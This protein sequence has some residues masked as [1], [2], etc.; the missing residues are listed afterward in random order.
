MLNKILIILLLLIGECCVFRFISSCSLVALSCGSK[1][2]RRGAFFPA[3]LWNETRSEKKVLLI[4]A[5]AKR[6]KARSERRNIA[7]AWRFEPY[8]EFTRGINKKRNEE[9]YWL[10]P[11]HGFATFPTQ[12]RHIPV[13]V[14]TFSRKLSV[15]S[16]AIWFQQFVRSLIGSKPAEIARK[17]MRTSDSRSCLWPI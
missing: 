4:F 3:K 17:H 7:W 8:K 13:L 6:R 11:S 16:A 1:S 15:C 5:E 9:L 10:F 12:S 14:A 2:Q